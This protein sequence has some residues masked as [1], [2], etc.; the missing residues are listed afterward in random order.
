MPRPTE[1]NGTAKERERSDL[2]E[3]AE[4]LVDAEHGVEVDGVRGGGGEHDVDGD[5]AVPS[6]RHVDEDPGQQRAAVGVGA[7]ADQH[8][9]PLRRALPRRVL[10]R[11]RPSLLLPL[12]RP[13]HLHLRVP[14][15]ATRSQDCRCGVRV[16]SCASGAAAIRF[17]ANG[18]V[19]P[20]PSRCSSERFLSLSLLPWR[21]AGF[22][23]PSPRPFGKGS[24]VH[25]RRLAGRQQPLSVAPFRCRSCL[26]F[27]LFLQVWKCFSFL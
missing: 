9:P 23:L 3:V 6:G 16:L 10:R 17:T 22:S 19:L 20:A 13:G 24:F 26:I 1:I 25:L 2:L 27:P 4:P 7:H 8:R 12:L 14:R 11:R 15:D 5:D 18:R 21:L